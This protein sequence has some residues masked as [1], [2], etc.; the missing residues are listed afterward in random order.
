MDVR[1]IE[2]EEGSHS[3]RRDS[4][5]FHHGLRQVKFPSRLAVD[6]GVVLKH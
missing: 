5:G 2:V 6:I 1:V 4:E 3:G